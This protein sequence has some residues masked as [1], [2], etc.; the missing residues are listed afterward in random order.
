MN[1]VKTL[2]SSEEEQK[3]VS[4]FLKDG[5]VPDPYYDDD[6]FE[7]VYLMV[8]KRCKQIIEEFSSPI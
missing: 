8:E 4:L 1:D 7:P 2:A 6:Q 5:I 3:K